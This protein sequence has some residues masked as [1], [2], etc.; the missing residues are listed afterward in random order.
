MAVGKLT[1]G[2]RIILATGNRG[3]L[4]EIQSLLGDAWILIPQSDL[5]IDPA[6]ENGATFVEN[7]VIK[8]RHA[9]AHSGLPAIADDSGLEVD[10]LHGAPGIRSARYAGQFGQGA[11]AANNAKLLAE[12]AGVPAANRSARFRCVIA[13]VR[14][15]DDAAPVIAE[16]TWEGRIATR[17]SGENGFGYDP[18]FIDP[19][20]GLTVGQLDPEQKNLCSHRG[21]ALGRLCEVLEAMMGP[22]SS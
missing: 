20:S 1:G 8:A 13:F 17:C 2:Q 7:A 21:V 14:D 9:A 16:G 10:A 22:E 5:G 3:K 11:D 19:E 4:R 12:L 18:L 6:E 15:A